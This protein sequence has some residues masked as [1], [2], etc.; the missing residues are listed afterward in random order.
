[1][2]AIRSIIILLTVL[3]STFV[4]AQGFF[5]QIPRDYDFIQYDKNRLE[6]PGDTG[7]MC[8]LYEKLDS[9]VLCREGKVNILHIGGSHVQAD[10]FSNRI[11]RNLDSLNLDFKSSRGLVFPFKIAGTN[12]P[13]NYNVTYTGKWTSSRILKRHDNI[14]LGL[15][16]IAVQTNSADA[17]M[18]I[19]LNR[20]ETSRW[21]CT[22]I[23]LIGYSDSAY[24]YPVI[25]N[26]VDG[27]KIHSIYN[28]LDDVYEFSFENPVDSFTIAFEQTDSIFHPF[29]L[30]GILAENNSDGI[31]YNSVGINGASVPSWLKCEKFQKELPLVRPDLV[32]FGIGINDAVPKNFSGTKFIENYSKLIE[33]I[34]EISPNCAFIFITNNDSYR[35]T[36]GQYSVNTNGQ[37]VE[38]VF[39]ELAKKYNGAVWDQFAIMGGLKSMKKWEDAGLARKDKIHFSPKGYTLLGDLFYNALIESYLN[40]K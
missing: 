37:I 23:K 31:T 19:N 38:E 35:R 9:I 12:N 8:Y 13:P 3:S 11:R 25:I 15:M 40:Y 33:K 22:D 4:S 17:T 32:I 14:E 5:K 24:S 16:G 30:S 2:K 21:E 1:M 34:Q 26:P 6:F 36:K 18:K 39:F 7:T 29:T 20:D 28:V 10:V 27:S